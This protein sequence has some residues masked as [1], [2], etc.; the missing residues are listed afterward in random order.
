MWQIIL[1][2]YLILSILMAEYIRRKRNDVDAIKYLL[3]IL[4]LPIWFFAYGLILVARL[5]LGR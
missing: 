2:C 5:L 4:F 1:I 3:M